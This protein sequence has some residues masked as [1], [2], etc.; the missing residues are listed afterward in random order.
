[1]SKNLLSVELSRESKR[2]MNLLRT[3]AGTLSV[4]N[5]MNLIGRQYRQ[6]VKGIFK[7][8]QARKTGLKWDKLTDKTLKQKKK[9]G[10][11][12]KGILEREGT[13]LR[14]MTQKDH[15]DN[16]SEVSH[17]SGLFGSSVPLKLRVWVTPIL[18]SIPSLIFVRICL[19]S[20]ISGTGLKQYA[21]PSDCLT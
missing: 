17:F 14:S 15:A 12:N 7:K 13:L 11:E 3:H 9:L 21:S 18:V 20:C 5:S 6:E 1:M 10:F 2:L 4:K 19:L 8:K 16:I